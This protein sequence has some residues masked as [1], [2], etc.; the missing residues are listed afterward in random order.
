MST[1]KVEV[2]T[3]DKILPHGGADK[4]EIAVVKGWHCV[5]SKNSFGENDAAVYF[6]ID[7]VLPVEVETKIFGPES[8]VKLN[9]SRVRT[10]KLRGVVSQGLLVA[11]KVI[12]LHKFKVGDDLTE[13]LGVKK[14]EPPAAPWEGFKGGGGNLPKQNPN[15]HRYTSI[16][17]IKN[18]PHV[19]HPDDEVIITEKL[20]GTNSRFGYV[21]REQ[22]HPLS[23][24][25]RWFRRFG[26][27]EYAVGSHNRQVSEDAKN[28]Y[29]EVARK[30][31]LKKILKDGEV[32]YGEIVGPKIQ[33]HY[34]YGCSEP[35][36]VV[37]DIFK[38]NQYLPFDDMKNRAGELG[39]LVVPVLWRGKFKDA[40][41]STLVSGDS[42]F[43]PSQKVRE[44][45][46][47]RPV[48]EEYDYNVGRKVLKVISPEYLMRDDNTEYH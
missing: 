34:L 11:P 1:L 41:L 6:P 33:K 37:F 25:G 27:F 26:N 20:H 45:V 2:V 44:G 24:L 8:K 4:L 48:K 10:I 32:V 7:S 36:L 18:H 39:L 30:Y 43:A 14:Y 15:F 38:D 21:L 29:A 22:K 16:E 9:N 12:G 47:V 23:F 28:L 19:F 5:V 35:T 3:V 46:V 17:N 40:P 42:V 31:K 13:I